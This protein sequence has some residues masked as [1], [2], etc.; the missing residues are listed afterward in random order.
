M[1]NTTFLKKLAIVLIALFI[2]SCDKDYNTLGADIIGNENFSYSKYTA[3]TTKIYNQK[4]DAVETSNS[5]VNYLGIYE[6]TA[7]GVSK[8]SFITQVE[9]DT[10]NP[11]FGTN[12]VIDSVI[13]YV[14]Y[15]STK[16]ATASNGVTSYTL[17]QIYSKDPNNAV[18]PIDLQVYE[19][20][21]ALLDFD[22]DNNFTTRKKYFSNEENSLSTFSNKKI[23]LPASA[24]GT[25]NGTKLNNSSLSDQNNQFKAS[26]K[27]YIKKTVKGTTVTTQRIPP[28]MSLNLDIPYFQQRIVN[29]NPDVFINNI[30]FKE[31]FKGIYFQAQ[32]SPTGTMYSLDFKKGE[33]VIYYKENNAKNITTK[34][35]K[36]LGLNMKG[37]SVNLLENTTTAP[38]YATALTTANNVT[39]D[40]SIYLKGGQGSTAFID[41]FDAGELQTLRNNKWLI[42]DATLTFTVDKSKMTAPDKPQ[43]LY[44]YNADTN[45]ILFD[46]SFDNSR[47][48]VNPKL[49]KTLFGGIIQ[50]DANSTVETYKIRIAEH[51]TDVLKNNKDNVRLG[52]CITD[53]INVIDYGFLKTEIT[54]P[55]KFDRVPKSSIQTP[56]GTVLYGSNIPST[57]PDYDKRL[58]LEIYYTKPN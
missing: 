42:N 55:K 13:L 33:V 56:L 31:Y 43:R 34:E 36:T 2:V 21:Y 18:R 25:V 22:I 58:K 4:V 47:N 8:A 38:A 32:T 14:P 35:S 28:G 44:V 7:F 5:V 12:V 49:S 3:V 10:I 1:M 52:V 50:T 37:N 16:G 23:G 26:E 24:N 15:F 54:S 46:Y 19:N 41:L 40:Q 20:G 57:S 30:K 51:L 27:E 39:G 53:D 11:K 17:D 29:A 45:Q 48:T 9:L 6:N